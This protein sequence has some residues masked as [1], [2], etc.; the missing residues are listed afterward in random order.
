MEELEKGL[1]DRNS[2]V[3]PIESIIQ[4]PWGHSETK[5]PTKQH[6]VVGP[7]PWA[8]TY[9]ADVK[10]GLHMIPEQVVLKLSLQ[11]LRS[12]WNLFPK[13]SYF[14]QLLGVKKHLA[15]QR[16]SVPGRII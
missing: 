11:P 15:L 9:V 14:V 6:T 1:R 10:L 2:T 3:R 4:G 8:H 5:T 7:G 13:L 16:L 12:A